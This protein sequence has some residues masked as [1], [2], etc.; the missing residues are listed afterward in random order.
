MGIGLHFI[1]ELIKLSL[2]SYHMLIATI[3]FQALNCASLQVGSH[4]ILTLLTHFVDGKTEA[5]KG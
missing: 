4:L 2:L 3:I 5:M 1:L